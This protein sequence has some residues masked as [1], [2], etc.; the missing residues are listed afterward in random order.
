MISINIPG[1]RDLH[2][3]HLVLDYNGT[4]AA[5]GILIPNA[6]E[7][8]RA[9]SSRIQI[10]VIT[11]DT[12]GSAAAQL[13]A[14]PVTL[15]VIPLEDQAQAKLNYINSLGS[16]SVVAIGN[17]RNDREMLRVASVGIAL[18]QK[19]GASAQT[20]S[21]ADVVCTSIINALELLLHPKRLIATLRS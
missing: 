8:L 3:D 13:A 4:I 2:L 9:L 18:I 5:D 12:F 7:T 10:H 11:A 17:G 16:H 6:E 14:L 19:E 20:I 15:T 1:F 21:S